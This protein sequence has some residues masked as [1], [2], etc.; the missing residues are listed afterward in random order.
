MFIES[1][2]KNCKYI[3]KYININ[4]RKYK[5]TFLFILDAILGYLFFIGY[6]NM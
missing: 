2:H 6:M 3:Y 4:L 5:I 1:S